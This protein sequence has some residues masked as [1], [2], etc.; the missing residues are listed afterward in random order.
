MFELEGPAVDGRGG[1]GATGTTVEERPSS[2]AQC[3]GN[4]EPER[5]RPASAAK[6]SKSAA[7]GSNSRRRHAMWLW[8]PRFHEGDRALWS[9]L[10]VLV[11]TSSLIHDED[12]RPVDEFMR[13][14][15]PA[16]NGPLQL[17]P[18]KLLW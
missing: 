7:S 16:R 2:T 13:D 14:L 5:T 15:L 9:A 8:L 11:P 3:G 18:A 6:T 4:Q 12:P 17:L 1:H 10:V